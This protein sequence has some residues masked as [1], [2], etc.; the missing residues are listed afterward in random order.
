MTG[1][2]KPKVYRLRN[3]P[4][5]ADRLAV[6]QLVTTALNDPYI[7]AGDVQISSLAPAVELWKR[8]RT[9][10]AT[11]TFKQVPKLLASQSLKPGEPE[12]TF[13]SLAVPGLPEPLVLDTQFDGLTPLN[14]TSLENHEYDC[15]AISGLASH[16]FGSWQPKGDDKSFMWIRDT[17][18]QSLP[19]IRFLLYG[20][21]TSIVNSKSFQTVADIA[22]ALLSSLQANIWAETATKPLMFLAHSLGGVIL[23]KLLIM[24]AN[25]TDRLRSML[26]LVKG[27]IFFGTPS[28]GMPI[29]HL[30]SIVENQP[31]KALIE[32]LSD[33]SPFLSHLEV[34]FRGI[35]LLQH[36]KL[37]WAYETRTSPTVEVMMEFY[38]VPCSTSLIHILTKNPVLLFHRRMV[39][40][41]TSERGQNRSWLIQNLQLE[42]HMHSTY[43][44]QSQLTKIIRIW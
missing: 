33:H 35:S 38:L 6:T 15:I 30:L 5:H 39:T 2:S 32:A 36:M 10:V 44:R 26:Q 25:G 37:F 24:L 43:S 40:A 11:L 18:P 3:I 14:E 13:W 34:Q 31:N 17:L 4:A 41:F 19:N 20:Y 12:P 42:T 22:G 9:Q 27:A 16:P 23:K 7:T 21:D 1:A 8:W 28:V 29:S